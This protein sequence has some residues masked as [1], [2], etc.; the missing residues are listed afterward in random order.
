MRSHKKIL[1]MTASLI[2]ALTASLSSFTAFAA[3]PATTPSGE[4]TVTPPAA[5]TEHTYS[6]YQIFK[7]TAAYSSTDPTNALLSKIEWSDQFAPKATA[8][9]G[10]LKDDKAFGEGTANAFKDCTTAEQVANVLKGY[11]DNS[12]EAMAF[13]KIVGNFIKA[14]GITASGSTTSTN[15][16]ITGLADGYYVILD[17]G[18]G[19]A[20]SRNMLTI[21]G[22]EIDLDDITAKEVLPT[23]DKEVT[24]PNKID[25]KHNTASIG[26]TVEFKLTSA[27]PD[28]TGYDKYF[29]VINDEFSN[30]FTFLPDSL[31][32]TFG[33]DIDGHD[34]TLSEGT[35]YNLYIT[36]KG[37]EIVF[38]DFVD[39]LECA[40]DEIVVTYGAV[41]N[42]DADITTVGNTN[43][44]KLTYSNDPNT[45]AKGDEDGDPNDP[46]YPEDPDD[47]D[48]P[49]DEPG[50]PGDP[51][52]PDPGT[53]DD[54]T[55]PGD[56]G[57]TGITPP[58]QTTTY[59]TGVQIHKTGEGD[60][61]DG[62][63][64]A[65]FGLTGTSFTATVETKGAM[66][67]ASDGTYYLLKDGRYTTT[68]PT[69]ATASKYASTTKKYKLDT[70][71]SAGSQ[72]VKIESTATSDENGYIKF[73]GLGAGEYTLT[74]ISAPGDYNKLETPIVFTITA[75]LE[76]GDIKWSIS[77]DYSITFDSSKNLFTLTV[78]NKKGSGLP[79]TGS[80]G[81]AL[82]Y[83]SGGLLFICS[84]LFVVTKKRMKSEEI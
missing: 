17:D 9:I 15:S 45:A 46:N 26:D 40:G 64:G 56:S 39:W 44:V 14:Q 29:F 55:N 38:K 24:G 49:N 18:T 23:I 80:L 6:A 51:D 21:I 35:D 72:V 69:D 61:A 75:T 30:G 60:D 73:V 2:M 58:I 1:A 67:E 68:A 27:V 16:K 76:D 63:A 59:T 52:R 48:N 41:L 4:V 81:T 25:G 47:P 34:H 43:T 82:F 13:A 54:P 70:T 8:F 84:A 19:K 11:N 77:T 5:D 12:A 22:S 66:V 7:G 31:E 79:S 20:L 57:V 62:L 36:K 33:K 65:V 50:R 28:M 10:L 37:Y 78:E 3:P 32:I 53:P 83:F 74:E 42:A 71:A